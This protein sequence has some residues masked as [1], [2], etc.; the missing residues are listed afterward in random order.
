[1]IGVTLLIAAMIGNPVARLLSLSP[2]CEFPAQGMSIV[3]Q[4]GPLDPAMD[5]D[6]AIVSW[7]VDNAG[8]AAV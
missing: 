6:E 4:F 7:N 8:G 5:F 2:D 3:K 1:M